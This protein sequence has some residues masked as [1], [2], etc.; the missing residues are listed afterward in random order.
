MACVLVDEESDDNTI[1]SVA[2]NLPLFKESESDVHA[3]IAA[4]GS[5]SR[6]GK[7]T[8][9]ATAYITMP[10]CKRCFAALTVSGIKRIVTRRTPPIAILDC[11]MK[12]KV[13]FVS[14]S[15]ESMEQQT[16]RINLLIHG[17]PDGKKRSR[18][19]VDSS[20]ENKKFKNE[21]LSA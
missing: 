2:T 16:K 8:E 11:A 3:E 1:L 20:G 10:P 5:A 7:R 12:Q 17:H 9:N 6:V 15:R 14:L 4:L 13:E 19:E 18:A 21:K